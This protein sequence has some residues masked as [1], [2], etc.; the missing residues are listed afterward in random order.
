M[1]YNFCNQMIGGYDENGLYFAEKSFPNSNAGQGPIPLPTEGGFELTIVRPSKK[2]ADNVTVV[3]DG[4]AFALAH[5]KTD[6][7]NHGL[8]AYANWIES[9]RSRD[10]TGTWRSIRAWSTCRSLGVD[11]LAEANKRI[12]GD[13]APL[14]D[15]ARGHYEVVVSNLRPI[16]ERSAAAKTDKVEPIDRD[17]TVTQLAAAREAEAKGIEAL[18]KIVAAL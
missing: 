6:P 11:F 3:K 7:H 16:A 17:L 18:A 12:E 8:A 14:F 9:I 2:R 5:P 4:I 10:K 15:A 1:Y 13:V